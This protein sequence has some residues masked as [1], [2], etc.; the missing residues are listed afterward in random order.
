MDEFR[1]PGRFPF[2]Q[3][4]RKFRFGAK[5]KTF[6]R[7]ADWKIP[8]KSGTAQKVVPFFRWKFSDGTT[9][10]FYGFCTGYQFQAAHDHIFGKEIWR[11]PQLGRCPRLGAF[12][13]LRFIRMLSLSWPDSWFRNLGTLPVACT[14]QHRASKV[15]RV[16]LKWLFYRFIDR[17]CR[18]NIFIKTFISVKI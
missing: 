12:R 16:I 5:W 7:F 1:N 4:F 14:P 10:S 13:L 15:P 6:F 11:L 8:T 18:Q 3:K 9:C 17:I 2:G